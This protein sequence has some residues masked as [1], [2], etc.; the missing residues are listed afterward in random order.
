[1]DYVKLLGP[2]SKW[3]NTC[4]VISRNVGIINNLK[5]SL[6]LD[7]LFTLYNAL[8]LTVPNPPI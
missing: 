8:T 6:T 2:Y 5:A 3:I 7:V 1:M 4:S